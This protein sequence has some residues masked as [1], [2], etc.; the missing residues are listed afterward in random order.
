ML[1]Q[2]RYDAGK[3]L[4][5]KL[6]EYKDV[7]DVIILALPR[8]GVPV[9][10]EV[11]HE[12]RAPLDIFI[13]RKLGVPGHEELAMGAIASGDVLILN[14]G[15]VAT[16]G[17]TEGMIEAAASRE[18]EELRRRESL[19]R[20]GRPARNLTGKQIILVDDGLATGASMRAATTA[21][22]KHNPKKLVVAVPVAADE[23]CDEFRQE[24]DEVVCYETPE[25]FWAVGMWYLDF[26]QTQDR[27]VQS[28]L[29]SAARSEA[30]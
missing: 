29:D 6:L 4:A 30:A 25:P 24:V 15:L 13:V 20:R 23:T 12:L 18:A 2:D 17:I 14:E 19:Y 26:S 3:K 1:F 5:Q 22:K 21:I 8:G 7:N 11:A 28:L 9:A 27:E 16:L 10:F